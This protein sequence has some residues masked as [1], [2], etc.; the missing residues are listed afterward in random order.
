MTMSPGSP[1]L[2]T[3]SRRTTFMRAMRSPHRVRE[4][5]HLAR[6]LHGQG[7]VPLV[8]LAGAGYP[9]RPDLSTVGH[10]TPQQRRVL[11]V[12]VADLFLAEVADLR[13]ALAGEL[14]LAVAAL[15]VAP[16]AIAIA[17]AHDAAFRSRMSR[18]IVFDRTSPST[19]GSAASRSARRSGS[20]S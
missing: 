6:V 4:K 13:T 16:L 20:R 19:N 14:L 12:D 3:G 1:S 15:A 5:T 2:S 11:V 9:S 8:T 17:R 7:D 10:E 18:R